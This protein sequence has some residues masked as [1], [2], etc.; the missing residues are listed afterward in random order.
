MHEGGQRENILACE[1]ISKTFGGTKALDNVSLQIRKGEVHALLGENGAGKSTL[2]KIIVGLYR[3]DCGSILFDGESYSV[4]SPAEALQRGISMIHQELNIEPHLTIAEHIFLKDEDTYGGILLNKARTNDRAAKVLKQYG[5]AM[6]PK[7]MMSEL[8]IAQAQMIEIIKAVTKNAKL[9]I[10]D[11]PTSSLDSEET[12]RLFQTIRDLKEQGVSI[13]YISHRME[14]IFEICD[15]VSIFRDGRFIDSK[16]IGEV[17]QEQLIALMVGRSVD[18]IFPKTDCLIGE[19]VLTVE[20]LSGNGF[21]DISF[22]VHAGEI[23]GFSGL[24]GSGRSETMRA[25][26]GMDPIH[27][28]KLFLEGQEIKLKNPR[29]AIAKGICLVNEDRKQYGLCLFRSL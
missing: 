6:G 22:T 26:F 3:A 29:H 13:I 16:A 5:F 19:P 9:I 12:K 2:M 4:H 21:R 11:E 23:L 7:R 25:I 10:M 18:N 20:G 1:G 28:G 15:S 14:E 8:T 17:T 24:V 27:S